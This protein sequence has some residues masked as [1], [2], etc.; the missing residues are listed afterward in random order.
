MT[1]LTKN[2]TL[3]FLPSIFLIFLITFL[4]VGLMIFSRM[5]ETKAASRADVVAT[6]AMTAVEVIALALEDIGLDNGLDRNG[7]SRD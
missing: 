5:S 7:F 1:T 2:S 3:I 6:T 4:T